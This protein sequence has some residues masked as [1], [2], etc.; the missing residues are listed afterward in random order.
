VN[1]L[2]LLAPI[3]I[4][5]E[6]RV[7]V[8]SKIF[9]IVSLL[10]RR[11]LESFFRRR[12]RRSLFPAAKTKPNSIKALSK[13]VAVGTE[14]ESK[15]IPYVPCGLHQM[16]QF[17]ITRF[18]NHNKTLTSLKYPNVSEFQATQWGIQ[19]NAGFFTSFLSTLT[20]FSGTSLHE[21]WKRL[22]FLR[23]KT[24]IVGGSLDPIVNAEEL[25]EDSIGL[26]GAD[27]LEWRL[28]NSAH[29]FP[30]TDSDKVVNEICGFWEI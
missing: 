9:S 19:V 11:I 12:L 5:R 27:K 25:K 14:V 16:D 7:A 29:D 18:S 20:H 22:R 3:G 15:T 8:Q 26:L 6:E 21:S 10:P 17:L 30:V 23:G 1:S 28:I 13:V 2:V 24:L 4:I